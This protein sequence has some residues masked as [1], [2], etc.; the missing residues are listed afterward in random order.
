MKITVP[1]VSPNI[2]VAEIE[3]AAAAV[4]ALF[5]KYTA[6]LSLSLFKMAEA[7]LSDLDTQAVAALNS[8]K[9][10]SS[11]DEK[12]AV[13][14]EAIR[15]LGNV[16]T[17]YASLPIA[18][19]KDAAKTLLDIYNR[20]GRALTEKNFA[21]Q[22]ALDKSFL[23]DLS[24]AEAVAAAKKLEGVTEVI[25]SFRAAEADFV[26]FT[27]S[28]NDAKTAGKEKASSSLL[29]K[30]LLSCL[31]EKIIPLVNAAVAID[32]ASYHDFAAELATTITRANDAVSRRS[33][34]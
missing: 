8:V 26:A 17:G 19:K 7:E 10:L 16:L 24:S 27:A 28:Y 29:K 20:Y 31:N 6:V 9:T 33:K 25:A 30:Q 18:E 22:S 12:D 34:K 1:K 11:L 15:T 21:E 13:R 32:E 2:R 14:D 23:A 5:A 4:S 3:T